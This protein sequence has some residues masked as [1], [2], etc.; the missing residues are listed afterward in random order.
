MI[1]YLNEGTFIDIE[2]Q[3]SYSIDKPL[4]YEVALE[5]PFRYR[6]YYYDVET[7]LYYLMTRYYD[8]ETGRFIS[9]DSVEYLNPNSINGLN[10][11]SYCGNNP[12]MYSDENGNLP[13]WAKWLIGGGMIVGAI[14]LTIATA[15]LGGV[16]NEKGI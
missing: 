12:I 10:L 5:N 14:A 11:Y 3:T 1:Y 7:K 15:G 13:K 16:F 9:M 8:P 2:T 4:S 6:G